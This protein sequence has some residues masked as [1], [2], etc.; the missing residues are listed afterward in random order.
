MEKQQ[1]SFYYLLVLVCLS[2]ISLFG[3]IR[4]DIFNPKAIT[5]APAAPAVVSPVYYCQN[6][7]AVQLTATPSPGSTLV[8]YGTSATGGIPSPTAPTPSTSTVGTTRYYVSQVDG[9]GVSPRAEIVVNVVADNGSKILLFRCD[10]SQ[11]AA[12]DK[13]SSVFFDWTN[14]LTLPN[15][16]TYSYTIDGG[17][18][19]RGTATNSNLQVFGLLP[20]Q[21]V[22]LTLW[23]TT[24]P[25]DRSVLT[26]SVPC[27]T[28]TTTPDF[29]Q[30]PPICSGDAAPVLGNRSPNGITGTWSPSAVDNTLTS[31]YVFI[32]DLPAFPCANKQTMTITVGAFKEPGFED[33]TICYDRPPPTLENTSPNGITGAWSPNLIDNRVPGSYVFTPDSD[34]CAVPQTINV[35]VKPVDTLLDFQW[36]VTDAFSDNQMITITAEAGDIDYLY[37]LDDGPFQESPVFENVSS[38][39]HT[40]TVIDKYGCSEAIIQ[41]NILVIGY[42]KFFTPNG[43]DYNDKWNIFELQDDLASKIH[44]FD[45]YGKLLKEIRPGGTGWDGTYNGREMPGN[46]Y[47]FVVE[48]LEDGIFKKYKSHFSLKR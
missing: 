29:A 6:S 27:G 8:W 7:V 1:S 17:P 43:D 16:Y 14:T 36:T 12:A 42:P 40:V 19:V 9:T 48:Y 25:C 34:P 39:Y 3:S 22:T 23:H 31:D 18:A 33:L 37:Q 13:N 2:N 10:P 15:Q 5:L 20:G 44:I 30:I 28:A 21:S 41:P 4:A 47:W 24:Y 26:C 38:G 35:S 11:I 32:P 46:D 45:R